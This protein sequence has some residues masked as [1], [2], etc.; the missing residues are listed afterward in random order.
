MNHRFCMKLLVLVCLL[1]FLS[2]VSFGQDVT[3]KVQVDTINSKVPLALAHLWGQTIRGLTPSDVVYEMANVEIQNNAAQ[4]RTFQLKLELQGL[5]P[6]AIKT[7]QVGPMTKTVVRCS[8][9]LDWNLA[10]SY[11]D[12]RI[13]KLSVEL[14]EGQNVVYSD[15]LNVPLMGKDDVPMYANSKPVYFFLVTRVQPKSTLVTQVINEASQRMGF[16]WRPGIS[17]YQ[18]SNNPTQMKE[19]IRKI[20]KTIQAMDFTYVNTPISF[21]EGYQR[22][23]TPAEALRVKAGNCIDGTLVFASCISAIG[24]DPIIVIIPRH[25]FV[26]A[27]IPPPDLSGTREARRHLQSMTLSGGQPALPTSFAASWVPIETTVLQARSKQYLALTRTTFEEA[28][29][30]GVKELAAA[31]PE[32]VVLIDVEAWRACGLLPAP[33]IR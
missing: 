7:V 14:D 8:P 28:M 24:Y 19:D 5:G 4:L 20:Y 25:A 27:A 22:I 31:G 30:I 23:K 29:E 9:G 32:N 1:G 18:G 16:Q 3:A 17:G 33:E 12:E 6:A 26:I 2:T 11:V 21:E 15:V 10:S 13:V